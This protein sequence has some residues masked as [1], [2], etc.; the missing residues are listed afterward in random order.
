MV[1][2]TVKINSHSLLRARDQ[3]R[4]ELYALT[5]L[6]STCL[7]LGL[8]MP[9]PYCLAYLI[10]IRG[11]QTG[12][13]IALIVIPF[14]VNQNRNIFLTCY[15]NELLHLFECAFSVI[16]KQDRKSTRLNSSHVAIPYA[17]FCWK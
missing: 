3:Q 15:L 2:R 11:K 6:L 5:Q 4:L 16:R 9:A 7:E 17:V 14:G 10:T 12:P 8:R 1:T 13:L